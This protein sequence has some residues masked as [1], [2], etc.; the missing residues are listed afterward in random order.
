MSLPILFAAETITSQKKSSIYTTPQ[1][2]QKMS[3]P[4]TYL[5]AHSAHSKLS[6]EAAR[7]DHHL[8]LLV[9]HA[10]MLDSLM[11]SLANAQQQEERRFNKS[12]FRAREDEIRYDATVKGPEGDWEAEDA[13]SSDESDDDED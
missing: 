9:G 3:S 5:L 12:P 4:Q 13:R 7:A 11:A 8:R 2:K 1:K 6:Q 10:N